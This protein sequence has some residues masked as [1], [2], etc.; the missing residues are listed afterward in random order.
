MVFATDYTD[1]HR[2]VLATDYTNSKNVSCHRLRRWAQIEK[3]ILK[4][5]L[6]FLKLLRGKYF[7][8]VLW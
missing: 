1:G 5:L 8:P 3:I 6:F 2:K 4:R 7:L